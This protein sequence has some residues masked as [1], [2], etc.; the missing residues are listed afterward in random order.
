MCTYIYVCVCTCLCM[1]IY[2]YIFIN[3]CVNVCVYIYI[4]IY[5]YE[6]KVNFGEIVHLKFDQGTNTYKVYL[7]S[8]QSSNFKQ[9]AFIN[10]QYI[11]VHNMCVNVPTH[12]M[13]EYVCVYMCGWVGES[14]IWE[15][16]TKFALRS[17]LVK[18]FLRGGS[19]EGEEKGDRGVGGFFR[20]RVLILNVAI[21]LIMNC[22]SLF[23]S[24]SLSVGYEQRKARWI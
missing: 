15:T 7:V 13:W 10:I 11:N 5:T 16:H 23:L 4:Y 22:I 1:Y 21:F 9:D 19:G 24:L 8:T 6:H 2:T 17:H 20:K 18:Q 3:F 12:I 14:N